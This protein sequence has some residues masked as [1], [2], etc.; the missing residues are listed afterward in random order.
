MEHPVAGGSHGRTIVTGD[1]HQGLEDALLDHLA[2][3]VREDPVACRPVVVPTNLLK[4]RLSRALA[5]KIGGHAN[6]RFMT[7]K[8]LATSIAPPGTLRGRALLPRRADEMIVRRLLDSGIARDGYFAAIAERPGLARALV[9]AIRALKEAS[10]DPDGLI[11]AA[12][13]ARLPARNRTAKFAELAR[14]WRAY[15]D[16]L[17]SGDWADDADLMRT[18]AETL[19]SD[20]NALPRLVLYGF[21]D[22]NALQ[23]RLVAAYGE[24]G[25]AIVFFPHLE[26]ESFRYAEGTLDWF[27][28]IGFERTE[29]DAG[30]ARDVPLPDETII[31]SA[32]GEAREARE[33]VR[34]IAGILRDHADS[35]GAAIDFQDV[36]VITRASA[37]YSD[38][39][40]EELEHL[41]AAELMGPGAGPYLHTPP[42]LSRTRAGRSLLALAHVGESDFGREEVIEFLSLADLDHDLV[43]GGSGRGEVPASDWNKASILAGII[44][45]VDQWTPKLAALRARITDADPESDF[46]A[47]HGHLAGPIDALSGIVA[48]IAEELGKTAPRERIDVQVERLVGLYEELT[49]APGAGDSS[50]DGDAQRDATPHRDDVLDAANELRALSGP[51][52]EITFARF[53]ELLR[54]RLDSPVPR[55]EKFERGGPTVLD[56]MAGRGLSYEVVVVPGLVEKLFPAAPRQ[57]PILLDSERVRLN[58]ARDNDPLRSLPDRSRRIDEERLL[59]RLAVGSARKVLVLTYPRLDPATARPRLPSTFVLRAHEALTGQPCDYETLETSDRVERIPLSRRFPA[60]RRE[61]LTRHEFDGCSI[62]QAFESGDPSEIAYLVRE[63]GPLGRRLGMETT[64]WS[65]PHF[66]A[67]DGAVRS[68][69][70]RRAVEELSGF[71]TDGRGER[72]VPATTLEEYALCPFRFFM[73]HVL[74]IEPMEE[75]DE[76]LELSP[77]D[78][79][80]L[81]HAVLERFMRTAKADGRLPLE[82]ASRASLFETAERIARS[83]RWSIAGYPGAVELAIRSLRTDLGLW[84]GRELDEEGEFVP[85]YFEARFGGALREH[86]DPELSLE[87]G[88]PFETDTGARLLMSGKID[89]IDLSSDGKRAR[90]LDYKTGRAPQGGRKN[91]IVLDRGRRLQ[92]PVYL[93]ASRRMLRDVHAG[94]EVESAEYRFLR[95]RKASRATLALSRTLLEEHEDDLARAVGLILH[96]IATGMF[97]QFPE[98][99]F[100]KNCDYAEA[101]PATSV[102]LTAMKTHDRNAEFYMSGPNG[103]LDIE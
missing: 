22:L 96:G 55:E 86:D 84:F 61:A 48:R 14:I 62:L 95:E 46:A 68:K 23:K 17:A 47:R 30:D 66:T 3:C 72:T 1:F 63:G 80:S 41:G 101:C 75:P 35:D 93:L 24:R 11:E 37:P 7:L 98:D 89:R 90:V 92:L 15:E 83:G 51:A 78:R 2:S 85:S 88:I 53:S 70:A 56:V 87:E 29:I 42:P 94:A 77:R 97:F 67:Y 52:G 54:E 50:G 91:E 16:D 103:L 32:P 81:Y 19:E 57:D 10:F 45:G 9:R 36:A 13:A 38:L 28:S 31:M 49:R 21:Y 33:C 60:S 82:Q 71:R 44:S 100:C 59:F 74:G 20:G 65:H 40:A 25:G 99:E 12:T 4:L 8:D 69:D 26:I 5:R 102:A 34:R 39:F 73:H 27:R 76:A 18:A 58:E 79:G 43:R 6:L 64:R